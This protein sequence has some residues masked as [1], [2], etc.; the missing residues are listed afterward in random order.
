L[1]RSA[2]ADTA[3]LRMETRLTFIVDDVLLFI[4]EEGKNDFL[5]AN[6][7]SYYIVYECRLTENINADW[8][9]EPQRIFAL[10]K[11]Q[12]AWLESSA[13]E[14]ELLKMCLLGKSIMR[15]SHCSDRNQNT[16]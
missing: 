14:H 5:L 12:L 7:Y 6:N 11:L 10:K 15:A 16:P 3:R 2:S 4:S 1:V 9:W 8:E 13:V